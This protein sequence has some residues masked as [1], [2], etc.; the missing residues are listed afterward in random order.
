MTLLAVSATVACAGATPWPGDPAP[1]D[2]GY[3]SV[4]NNH[5]DAVR[6]YRVQSRLRVRLGTLEP[7]RSATYRLPPHITASGG[8]VRLLIDPMGTAPTFLT[9]PML[10]GPGQSVMMQVSAGVTLSH[11]WVSNRRPPGGER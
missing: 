9:E 4:T 7:M 1:R 2:A 3:I 10:V 11:Y 6:V 8:N 5:H